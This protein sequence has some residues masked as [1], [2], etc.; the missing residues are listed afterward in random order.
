MHTREGRTSEG[1]TED[2][3]YLPIGGAPDIA[4]PNSIRLFIFTKTGAKV[5]QMQPEMGKGKQNA[6]EN[7]L[8]A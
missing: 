2:C 4:I 8:Y 6:Y 1:R 3:A 7:S 5:I